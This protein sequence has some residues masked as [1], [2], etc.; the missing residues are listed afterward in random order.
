[1]TAGG[2]R[3]AMVAAG[4]A[5]AL[6]IAAL[7]WAMAEARVGQAEAYARERAAQRRAVAATRLA[8]PAAPPA[9]AP[10]RKRACV[11][12]LETFAVAVER[13]LVPLADGRARRVAALEA[14]SDAAIR[15]ERGAELARPAPTLPRRMGLEGHEPVT[16]ERRACDGTG[17]AELK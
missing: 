14:I 4:V 3:A 16:A 11:V 5:G 8:E 9:S 7:A 12:G 1:M 6:G 10:S 17:Y 15:A 13:A 2:R